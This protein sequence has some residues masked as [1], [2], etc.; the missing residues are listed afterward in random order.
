MPDFNL[1][2]GKLTF[3]FSF[4]LLSL[5]P[6]ESLLAQATVVQE[7]DLFPYDST[8]HAFW[9]Y[10]LPGDPTRDYVFTTKGTL[11]IYSDSSAQITG[12]IVNQG[13]PNRQWEVDFWLINQRDYTDW[14]NLG[15]MLKNGGGASAPDQMDWLFWELDSSRSFFYGVPGTH[16]DGDTLQFYHNPVNFTYGFQLG[17]GANDKNGAFGLSGWFYYDGAY[18]GKGDINVI[19]ECDSVSPPPPL[20]CDVAIDTVY[21]SCKTDSS[22]EMIITISGSG[23]NYQIT[24][25]QGTAPTGGLIA[26]TYTY[27]EYLNSTDVILTVEDPS[28]TNCI[29]STLPLTADC[30]PVAVCDLAIDTVFTQCLTDS[31]FEISVTFQGSSNLYQLSDDQSTPKLQ[32]L[33]A[34]TYTYGNY[35]QDTAV[36]FTV[37]DLG[38]F[39]CFFVLGPLAET[40]SVDTSGKRSPEVLISSV[41]PNPMRQQ[42]S[43]NVA[44][45]IEGTYLEC[46]IVD[47]MGRVVLEASHMLHEGHQQFPVSLPNV[48]PGLYFVKFMAEGEIISTQR[49][50]VV[51]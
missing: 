10:Q 39:G 29:E 47:Q 28:F 44:T 21:T 48:M 24:D 6:S 35:S 31:T 23:T 46:L 16:Y 51:D 1:F 12:T 32:N 15:R 7:C 2:A 11:T 49:L 20:V 50:L 45:E 25:D 41:Y 43:F 3:L 26:G 42:A 22:F 8:D 37:A 36:L 17:I 38:V 34:G 30:T 27:G 33:S 40:C 9:M 4:A 13:D 18:S 19:V 14:I 5:F